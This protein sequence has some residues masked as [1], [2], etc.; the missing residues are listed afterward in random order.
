MFLDC[1]PLK[2]SFTSHDLIWSFVTGASGA[3]Y[4]KRHWQA[5]EKCSGKV[6]WGHRVIAAI[7]ALPLLGGIAAVIERISYLV[8]NRFF[9][10]KKNS[11]NSSTASPPLK[12]RVETVNRPET[13]AD[14]KD[15]TPLRTLHWKARAISIE[16]AISKMWKNAEKAVKEHVKKDPES[17]A[18]IE[19]SLPAAR[20]IKSDSTLPPLKVSYKSDDAKGPRASMEDVHFFHQ[21]EQ[22]VIT[23]VF[24]G[25]GGK[26]VGELASKMFLE[27]FFKK[28]TENQGNVHQ[29]FELLIDEL[30][31]QVIQHPLYDCMGTTA[32]ICYIDKQTHRIYT[33][34]IGDSEA[35]IYRTINKKL[36]SV[37]LSCV[38][39]WSSTKDAKRASIALNS[40]EIETKWPTAPNPKFL[41][42]PFRIGINVSRSIGD[43][44][45]LGFSTSAGII[46]K[47]KI[48][49]NQL[50][51]GDVLIIACD[52]LKDYVSESE[53]L[54][55]IQN[56]DP[57][58]KKSFASELVNHAIDTKSAQDN[59]TV[60]AIDI[61]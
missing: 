42:Y 24:D 36:K 58:S 16:K 53:I 47:P 23:G 7:E 5:S 49:M 59:V 4:A 34:T 44:Q 11:D 10:T 35:N 41:R 6:A 8:L 26:K 28:L 54:Q 2:Y 30:Q 57:N 18:T 22:A 1:H 3:T 40:P 25:H 13:T 15:E 60:I 33:A 38:R 14:N 51:A 19:E 9:S 45:Y 20:D 12:G 29:T 55:L 46:H 56:R 52:G 50:A 27:Q 32:V 37:P 17:Y 31:K 39:D 43:G 61:A 48:T 21:N